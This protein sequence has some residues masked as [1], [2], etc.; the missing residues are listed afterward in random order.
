MEYVIL[1]KITSYHSKWLYIN[2]DIKYHIDLYQ[3]WYQIWAS[4]LNFF[5]KRINDVSSSNHKW[6]QKFILSSWSRK[7]FALKRSTSAITRDFHFRCLIGTHNPEMRRIRKE[8]RWHLHD[9][10]FNEGD[11]SRRA[12]EEINR[13]IHSGLPPRAYEEKL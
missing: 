2:S 7:T 12:N 10:N 3:Y 8:V 11:P 4:A 5:D 1:S 13:F 6:K 9:C